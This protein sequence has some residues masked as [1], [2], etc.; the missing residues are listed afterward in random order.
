MVHPSDG[1]ANKHFNYGSSIFSGDKEC[2]SWVMYKQ[3]QFIRVICCS[4][5]LADDT[6]RICLSVYFK[7]HENFAP[8]TWHCSRCSL[9]TSILIECVR[10]YIPETMKTVPLHPGTVHGVH[11]I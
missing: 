7:D 3:I 4:L 1:E 10:R 8:L 6:H 9:H 11:Y 5:L 2:A